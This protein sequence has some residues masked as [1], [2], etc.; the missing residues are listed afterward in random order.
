M[1][2]GCV[3]KLLHWLNLHSVGQGIEAASWLNLHSVGQGIEAASWLNPSLSWA[4]HLRDTYYTH[5]HQ[6]S[7]KQ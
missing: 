7:N 3:A 1:C 2:N 5:W 6:L 4:R